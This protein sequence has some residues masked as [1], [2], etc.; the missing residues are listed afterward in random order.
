MLTSVQDDDD[1]RKRQ[2]QLTRYVLLLCKHADVKNTLTA[3]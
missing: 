2:N 1:E 3:I